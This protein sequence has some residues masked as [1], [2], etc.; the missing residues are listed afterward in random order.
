METEAIWPLPSQ[1]VGLHCHY[2]YTVPTQ[3]GLEVLITSPKI[4]KNENKKPHSVRGSQLRLTVVGL[5]H[6]PS[7]PYTCIFQSL[8]VIRSSLQFSDLTVQ[9]SQPEGGVMLAL[10][11]H[12]RNPTGPVKV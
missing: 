5:K 12:L 4:S 8:K 2:V 9:V 3:T 1:E 10:T 7:A 11:N 6:A